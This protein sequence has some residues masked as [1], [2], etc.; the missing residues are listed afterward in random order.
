MVGL[1][2]LSISLSRVFNEKEERLIGPK[3][4]GLVWESFPA[5]GV[6]I[7]LTSSHI[8]GIWFKAR[9]S[10]KMAVSQGREISSVRCSWAGK[11]PSVV[12]T[13]VV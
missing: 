12:Y 2:W 4:F 8:V 6:K 7:T 1:I 13:L 3:S 10:W 11:N 9:Q 5:F